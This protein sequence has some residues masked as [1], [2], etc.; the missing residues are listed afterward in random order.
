MVIKEYNGKN[1]AA[2]V[3]LLLTSAGNT[4]S[5]YDLMPDDKTIEIFEN[6]KNIKTV[7][8]ILNKYNIKTENIEARGYLL[9]ESKRYAEK[10]LN[11]QIVRIMK[12]GI[13]NLYYIPQ[14]VLHPMLTNL[15]YQSLMMMDF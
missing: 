14:A 2:L 12:G 3:R 1:Q 8:D 11:P 6:A 13:D 15:L 5:R 9:S 7:N 10:E 4:T